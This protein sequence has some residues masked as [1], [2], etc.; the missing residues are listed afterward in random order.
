MAIHKRR[1]GGED[2]YR[3]TVPVIFWR[4]KIK[5]QLQH[6]PLFLYELWGRGNRS[7]R[8]SCQCSVPSHMAAE[9][10]AGGEFRST[11]GTL[12]NL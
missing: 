1:C 7:S 2:S 9:S 5:I 6:I 11:D 12:M 10:L 4:R 3:W 8:G